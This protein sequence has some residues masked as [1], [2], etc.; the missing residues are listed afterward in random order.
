MSDWKTAYQEGMKHFAQQQHPAAVEAFRRALELSPDNTEVL[1][2][3][4]MAL[5]HAGELDDAIATGNRIVELDPEDHFAHTSLSMFYQ[6]KGLIPEAEAEA[7]KARL[8]SWKQE[9]KK[10]PHAPPPPEA[11]GINVIQ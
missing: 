4:A 7:A 6:R 8:I 1:H 3:L 9:L 11:G 5:M 10:N 2:G